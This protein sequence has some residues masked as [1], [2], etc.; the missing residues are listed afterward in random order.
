MSRVFL[1]SDLHLGHRSILDFSPNRG[2]TCVDTHDE[3]IIERWNSVVNKRDVVIV[4]GDVAFSRDALKKVGRLKGTKHLIMG[5]HDVYGV[6]SYK[7]YFHI[8]PG[9]DRYKGFWLSHCPI[10]PNEMRYCKAN[11]HGHTHHNLM[12]D[13][14]INV[15]VEHL[16]GVPILFN[17]IK[18]R[19]DG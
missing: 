4:L 6:D 5:N 11:I 12:G 2:G 16:Q 10:H 3:W 15:C 18:R 8:R 7:Q 1:I 17:D 9:L 14:Y 19:Y 13:G